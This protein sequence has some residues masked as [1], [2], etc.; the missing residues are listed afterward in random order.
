MHTPCG[1]PQQV[2]TAHIWNLPTS[3][4]RRGTIPAAPPS[5]YVFLSL[6]LHHDGHW[7]LAT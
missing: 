2:H 7:Q 3:L 1:P 5:T 4:R 6:G